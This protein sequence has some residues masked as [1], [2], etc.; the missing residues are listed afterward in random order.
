MNRIKYFAVFAG[1]LPGA[2]WA[3]ASEGGFVLLLPTD[4]YIA[5]GVAAVAATVLLL[6]LLPGRLA[7]RLFAAVPLLPLPRTRLRLITSALSAALLIFAL[8]AGREGPRDPLANPLPLLVWSIFWIGLVSLQGLFGNHWRWTSPWVAPAAGL[9]WLLGRPLLRYPRRLGHA[10]AIA[11]YLGFASIL[12][13]DI[14]PSDPARL[15]GYVGIYAVATL[16]LC[17]V[18]GP[19]WLVRGEGLTVLMRA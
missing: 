18:F 15:A 9:R 19:A 12:L 7:E 16:A 3:H 17:A 1:L 2:A 8:W 13:A 10:P 4:L 14:A 6:A 11:T 5:G